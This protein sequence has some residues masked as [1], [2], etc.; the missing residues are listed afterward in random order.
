MQSWRLQLW[1]STSALTWVLWRKPLVPNGI[2][3]WKTIQEMMPWDRYQQI[4]HFFWSKPSAQSCCSIMFWAWHYTSWIIEYPRPSDSSM[5]RNFWLWQKWQSVR[6]ALGC[7]TW[8]K[9]GRTWLVQI[10]CLLSLLV[11]SVWRFGLVWSFNLESLG[12][13][14]RLVVS[15]SKT[16]KDQTE[17]M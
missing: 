3:K 11:I 15:G 9:I 13:R 6:L 4:Q 16:A 14:P 10:T 12:P 2:A 1:K 7:P 5:A 8:A 17:L